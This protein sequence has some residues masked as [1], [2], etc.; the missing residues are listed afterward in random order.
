VQKDFGKSARMFAKILGV[1]PR[2]AMRMLNGEQDIN[3]TV[4]SAV[5]LKLGYSPT[6]F[7][8]GTGDKKLKGNEA[9]LITEIQMLRTEMDI[10]AKLNLKLQARMTGIE[11]EYDLLKQE[12]EQIKQL[13]KK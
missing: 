7:L 8:L 10:G 9:K 12:L 13:I 6:W 5:C 11:M 4:I 2:S 3:Y 1:S